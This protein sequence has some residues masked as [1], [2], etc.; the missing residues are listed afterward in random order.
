MFFVRTA[1]G[2]VAGRPFFWYFSLS[3]KEKYEQKILN[4]FF[5]LKVFLGMNVLE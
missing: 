2:R 1:A 5:Y 4:V 3:A